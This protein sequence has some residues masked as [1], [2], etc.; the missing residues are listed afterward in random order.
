M[1]DFVKDATNAETT[2]VTTAAIVPPGTIAA[3]GR[4][5]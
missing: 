5:G 1:V 2:V 4:S 3:N